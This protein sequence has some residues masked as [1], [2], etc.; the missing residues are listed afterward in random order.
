M[1]NKTLL[2]VLAV[3]SL[4]WAL[5]GQA[6]DWGPCEATGGT[7]VFSS[8]FNQ[9]VSNP[10]DNY[11]GKT[12]PQFYSWDLNGNYQGKCECPDIYDLDDMKRR[13][14]YYKAVSTL[15]LGHNDGTQFYKIN[16]NLEFS[17]EVWIQG[18]AHQYVIIPFSDFNNNPARATN[19]GD[20]CQGANITTGSKGNITL[21]IAKPF[22][23]QSIIPLTELLSLY[24][25]MVPGVYS[26]TAMATVY[27]SGT[28]TVNQGCTIPAGYSVEIPFGEYNAR[29]FKDKQGAKPD[30][31]RE[32]AKTL[33][34]D[35]ANVS[36]G[37]KISLRL[38]GIPSPNNADAI[39]MGNPD[40][41]AIIADAQGNV[42]RPNTNDRAEMTVDSLY[43]ATHRNASI[44]LKAWPISTTG[45]M[46]QSGDFSGVA[47]INVDVE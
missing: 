35:C 32:I 40:I 3:F 1:R 4:L 46:P 24:G 34:F 8:S 25:T 18:S 10:A 20:F 9:T 33:T 11:A 5:P 14:I 29:D 6:A 36:D 13:G 44:Q 17:S 43:D 2:N 23:G 30:G 26:A 38:S 39:D 15:P 47:T 19:F 16:D 42:L 28:V 31:V 12:F 21:Y 22:V 37:V 7:N 41:G 27:I 45:Q